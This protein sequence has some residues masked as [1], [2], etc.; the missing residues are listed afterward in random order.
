MSRKEKRREMMRRLRRAVPD[1]VIAPEP[2]PLMIAWEYKRK[3][4][5][6]LRI[7]FDI[8]EWFPSGKDLER[9]GRLGGLFLAPLVWF[10]YLMAAFLADGFIFGENYKGRLLR[11]LM[12]RK[13]HVELTY[14]PSRGLIPAVIPSPPGNELELSYSGK[15][16]RE[17]GTE[18]FL[19]MVGK[20]AGKEKGMKIRLM[21]IGFYGNAKEKKYLEDILA[22]LPPNVSVEK[23]GF[24]PLK[25][26]LGRIASSHFFFDLRERTLENRYSLP[27][28]L[29]YY[30]ALGRPLFF[31][32]L[33]VIRSVMEPPSF[34]HLV[35][36]H[37]TDHLVELLRKYLQDP[38]RYL[39]ECREAQEL[40]RHEYAWENIAPQLTDFI[41]KNLNV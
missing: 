24:L 8:T 11:K 26:Y 3:N 7:L 23:H 6:N 32:D 20:L 28:K 39:E 1:V 25:E 40:A 5:K 2:F 29:F 18:A 14:Y 12:P 15:L 16:N 13:P 38:S 41:H 34:L 30:M 27:I 37:D 35:D 4:R 9:W 19:K 33:P 36:P 17:K 22:Q 31:S 10:H 21:L